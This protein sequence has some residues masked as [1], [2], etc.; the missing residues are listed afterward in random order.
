MGGTRVTRGEPGKQKPRSAAFASRLRDCGRGNSPEAAPKQMRGGKGRNVP[1]Q[2]HALRQ[3]PWRLQ[4][5]RSLPAFA[6]EMAA[7]RNGWKSVA[8]KD[9]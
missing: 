2:L 1:R 6:L 4:G 8:A 3:R 9:K 5:A 7:K